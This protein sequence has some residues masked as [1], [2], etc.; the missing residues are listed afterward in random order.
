MI[1]SSRLPPLQTL[2]VFEAAAR[3]L[4]FTAAAR[5]LGTTQSAVSQQVRSLEEALGLQLFVRVYRGVV[6]TRSGEALYQSVQEGFQRIVSTLEELQQSRQH[7][8]LNVATDF[9]LA[10]YWLVP[11]LPRFRA[12]H[13]EVDVRI[14]TAQNQRAFQSQDVDVIISFAP[15]PPRQRQTQRLFEER[16]FP[17]C[18]P[19]FLA[20]HGPIETVQ[21]LMALPLLRLADEG[22]AG[23]QT[24]DSLAPALGWHDPVPEPVLTFDNYTLLVQAAIAGQGIGLGWGTL[25]DDVV[26]HRLLL[27]LTGFSLASA[28][29]YYLSEARPQERSNAK[30]RF[31]D[32]VLSDQPPSAH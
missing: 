19:A 2:L 20:E 21:Q 3:N 27:P 12:I 25:L 26:E 7:Q 29:G 10:A 11:R 4:G 30:T 5:E 1:V 31:I 16:V 6:L 15:Q 18:S 14:I 8:S 17:V 23:W 28:G 22:G 9:A 13:P 32:W 24:W